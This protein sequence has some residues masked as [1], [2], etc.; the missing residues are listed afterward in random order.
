MYAVVR[1][2]SGSGVKELFDRLEEN[3][4][5]V[6]NLIRSIA[7]F[8]SYSLVRADDGGFSVTVCED[9]S[10]TDESIQ[11]TWDWV[12]KNASDLNVNPPSVTEGSV[13]IQ[14]S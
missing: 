7:G 1:N 2:Y 9:K 4:E 6:E 10:G 14:Q 13:I 11:V 8:V 3:K 12:Q 5:S